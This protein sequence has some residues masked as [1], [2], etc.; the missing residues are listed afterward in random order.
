MLK[1][2]LSCA[3]AC[4]SALLRPLGNEVRAEV[5]M[6]NPGLDGTCPKGFQY[7]RDTASC[8]QAN[9]PPGASRVY[10]L[11]CNCGEAWGRPF[12]TCYADGLATH[13]V[14]AG[15]A[16][17]DK[18]T[19]GFD[20]MIDTCRTGYA[21][22]PDG[23][24][25][26]AFPKSIVCTVLDA[27]GQP[28][29]GRDVSFGEDPGKGANF[30][31]TQRG[32][33]GADGAITFNVQDPKA[34]GIIIKSSGPEGPRAL[35]IRRNDFKGCVLHV[36][37][38]AGFEANIR[39]TYE[40]LLRKACVSAEDLTK[41]R[42]VGFD[43]S[44]GGK[45]LYD[46]GDNIIHGLSVSD[47]YGE[48]TRGMI[49]E[50]SHGMIARAIDAS[51]DV[52]GKHNNWVPV[53][54][55]D[56]KGRHGTPEAVAFEE[57]AADFVAMLYFHA[58]GEVYQADLADDVAAGRAIDANG[59]AASARTESV[60]T[61]YLWSVYQPIIE[62]SPD[63]PALALADFLRTMS[64]APRQARFG[65]AFTDPVRTIHEL[66]AQRIQRDGNAS[67][68]AACGFAPIDLERAKR[69]A[70]AYGLVDVPPVQTVNDSPDALARLTPGDHA[71][72]AG[73]EVILQDGARLLDQGKLGRTRLGG[74][75]PARFRV[76]P[77]GRATLLEGQAIVTDGPARTE[78]I[79][80]VPMGTGYTLRVQD[81][82]HTVAVDHGQVDVV[83]RAG[84][85]RVSVAAGQAVTFSAG[86]GFSVPSDAQ[87]ELTRVTEGFAT[88]PQGERSGAGGRRSQTT[89][90]IVALAA[91]A[92][93]VLL[94]LLMVRR[95]R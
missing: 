51:K 53:D 85:R 42:G 15:A 66:I 7:S 72:P 8:K 9:C 12:R 19:G 14:A 38:E 59:K 60:I 55:K 18:D 82:G 31:N 58:K 81:G 79:D 27:R 77:D 44:G 21:K 22:E 64:H 2:W 47:D 52:G 91:V 23:T 11:E 86:A 54:P 83:E 3:L 69:L 95:R 5:P 94:G 46:P 10:T 39:D 40:D 71:I 48:L 17:D 26:H 88:E 30:A 28:L 76:D 4:A 78:A 74:K 90:L 92:G 41:V 70:E 24:C 45:P 84:G 56:A 37:D 80:V 61:R 16:C 29:G 87:D 50:L 67:E 65:T 1:L 62:G 33:T 35:S 75:S 43:F 57:G 34:A 32:Q 49:H 73:T 6:H 20:A 93:F 25:A 13:C 68:R 89:L 63:G 36:V